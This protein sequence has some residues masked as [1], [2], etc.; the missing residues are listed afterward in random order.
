[1]PN[2]IRLH[3]LIALREAAG[4]TQADM[5]QRCGLHGNQSR[6]AVSAW[7]VGKTIPHASR[8]IGFMRYLW[9]DLHLYQ[10]P[11]A[12]A[13][14]WEILVEEWAW[15]ALEESELAQLRRELTSTVVV[16]PAPEPDA[17][18]PPPTTVPEPLPS[19]LLIAPP[20]PDSPL[21][22][23]TAPYTRSWPT[24][25]LRRRNWL[26]AGLSVLAIIAISAFWWPGAPLP[27]PTPPP[28]LTARPTS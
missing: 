28:S 13:E 20:L 25:L 23:S 26:L 22:Q 19:P 2:P 8:R 6:K 1:M 11:A 12:F 24:I 3:R 27:Q 9:H 16:T 21:P 15:E 7:E 5:A 10:N 18:D 14:L 4:L 17:V